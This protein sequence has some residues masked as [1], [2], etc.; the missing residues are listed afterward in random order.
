M[1]IRKVI[2]ITL[3]ALSIN[4]GAVDNDSN[5]YYDSSFVGEQPTPLYYGPIS[6]K[7]KVSS[8]D[9]SISFLDDEYRQDYLENLIE[10]EIFKL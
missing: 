6:S 7:Y 5:K 10:D 8:T 4:S 9:G 3:C 2:L 1:Q